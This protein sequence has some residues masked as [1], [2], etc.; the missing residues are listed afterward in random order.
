MRRA[1]LSPQSTPP[2]IP[3]AINNYNFVLIRNPGRSNGGLVCPLP[4][5]VPREDPVTGN[6]VPSQTGSLCPVICGFY[7]PT[8]SD[9]TWAYDFYSDFPIAPNPFSIANS[10]AAGFFL[11]NLL[12]PTTNVTIG[13]QRQ[14]LHHG[15][16]MTWQCWSRCGCRAGSWGWPASTCPSPTRLTRLPM[17]CSR[18]W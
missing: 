8:K 18:P 17:R 1:R 12:G 6:V 15:V 11:T 16:P 13:G 7:E 14:Q 3:S 10:L 4:I 5:P 9:V 2:A